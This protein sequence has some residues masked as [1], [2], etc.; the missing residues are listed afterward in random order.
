MGIN[1]YDLQTSDL[2]KME[3]SGWADYKI[4][5]MAANL[6]LVFYRNGCHDQDILVKVLLNEN[7]ATLPLKTDVAPFYHWQDFR[8]FYLQSINAYDEGCEPEDE[9][10]D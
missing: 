6:Q 2:D 8:D 9:E 1:G 5:P 4:I 3:H 7:E 10:D